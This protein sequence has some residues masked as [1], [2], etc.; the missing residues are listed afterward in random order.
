[1][2]IKFNAIVIFSLLFCTSQII[3][4]NPLNPDYNCVDME[5]VFEMSEEARLYGIKLEEFT[6]D[7]IR[8]NHQLLNVRKYI[9][10]VVFHV[11][12]TDFA[13]KTV[14]DEII[15]TALMKTNEDFQGLNDDFHDVDPIFVERRGTLDIEFRLATI[16]PNGNPTSGVLYYPEEKGLARTDSATHAKISKIAWNNYKYMNVYI[17]LDLIGNGQENNSGFAWYPNKW[18]SDLGIARVVYNGRYL[19]GNTDKEFASVLTHEFGHWLNLIHTFEGG[20]KLPN[21]H[22]D[23]TPMADQPAMGCRGAKN[24]KDEHI[25]GENY[26]DYNASCYK[27]FTRGQVERMIAA[28]HSGT[29]EPLWTYSNLEE[30]GTTNIKDFTNKHDIKI[31]PNPV[32]DYLEIAFAG[33]PELSFSGEHEISIYNIFGQEMPPKDKLSKIASLSSEITIKFDVSSFPPGMYFV[34]VGKMAAKFI[35]I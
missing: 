34:R 8:K 13:G 25:N 33:N 27:M 31:L 28:L 3:V 1:M 26:M 9:I 21:D 6:R 17:C 4:A 18:M 12:G 22:I 14:D 10:P 11:F 5:S 19:Y 15:R 35:K 29:R 2:K 16:D 7:F 30:T 32:A 24:C 23:D 20:C